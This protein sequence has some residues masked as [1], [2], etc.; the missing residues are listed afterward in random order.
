MIAIGVFAILT[1][2]ISGCGT[3]VPDLQE[4]PAKPGESAL[5]VKAIVDSIHCDIKNAVQAV[6]SEDDALAARHHQPRSAAWLDDWG[7]AGM[8]ILT[9]VE[10]SSTRR[11][12]PQSSR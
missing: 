2:V 8:L 9:I 7:V 1:A 4:F 3:Y 12:Y 6:I 5:L 10:R 11:L